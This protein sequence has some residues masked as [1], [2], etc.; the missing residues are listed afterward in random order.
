VILSKS[1]IKFPLNLKVSRSLGLRSIGL[2][3]PYYETYVD[4]GLTK[5]KAQ[6]ALMENVRISLHH[7]SLPNKFFGTN[8]VSGENGTSGDNLRH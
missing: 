8:I 3:G 1:L 4:V 7:T 6:I 2:Y 5:R